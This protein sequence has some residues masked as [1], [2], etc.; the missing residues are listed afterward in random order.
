MGERSPHNDVNAR[1]AFIGLSA[2]TTQAQMSRAVMEGVAFAL[3]D[4]L[5]VAIENG[6]VPSKVTVCGGG[7]KSKVWLQILA[8]ILN[9]PIAILTTEQG[10]AYG[11][12]IF[13]MVGYGQYESV[14]SATQSFTK[15]K[16]SIIP[17]KKQSA[18]YIEKY[19][20]F[21]NLYPIL[22]KVISA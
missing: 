3:K 8:D 12:A 21:R 16:N 4:C 22:K 14:E 6:F 19:K 1:G 5:N 18:I 11:A 2:T 13:A 17:D 15:I 10:P 9:L 7:A 20:V